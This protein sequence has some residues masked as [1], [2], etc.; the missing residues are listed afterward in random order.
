MPGKIINL[1]VFINNN[2]IEPQK[3]IAEISHPDE[4]KTISK[5]MMVNISPDE[6]KL[7]VFTL[8]IPAIYPA[9]KAELTI[10]I[11]EYQTGEILSTQTAEIEIGEFQNISMEMT[12]SPQQVMAGET[13]RS[14]FTIQN[15]G[16]TLKKVYIETR[17]CMVNESAEYQLNPGEIKRFT[18]TC[19]TSPDM[20]EVKK[21]F[22]TVRAVVSGEI[23]KSIFSS[24]DV[25]PSRNIKKDIYFRYPVTAS[26]SYLSTNVQDKYQAAYQFEISGNG[27]LDPEGKHRLEFMARGPNN[28]NLNFLGLYDQYFVSYSHKNLEMFVGEKAFTFTPLTESSRFGIGTENKLILNNGLS[29]GHLFVK[30]RFYN[31]IENE[32]AFFSN[33]DKNRNN[34]V[35]MYFIT[36]KGK[37][38]EDLTHLASIAGKFSLGGKTSA[39]LEFSRGVQQGIWDNAFNIN[40]NTQF[41]IF[42]LSGSYFYTGKDYPGYYSNSSFYSG[43]ATARITP[44]LNAGFYAKQDFA[45]AELDT[46]FITAPYSRILQSFVNYKIAPRSHLRFY[47]RE[48]ER[49]DRLLLKKFHYITQSL[50]SQYTQTFRKV[51]MNVLAELGETTNLML[52][53]GKNRLTTYRGSMNLMYRPSPLNSFRVFGSWSNINSFVSDEQRNLTAGIAVSSQL[54]KNFRA[55]FHLQNA[56]DIDDYYLNRNLMQLNLDYKINR[57]HSLTFRSFYTIFRQQTE[58]PEFTLS[59]TYTY[60]FGVPVKQVIKAGDV[61][62]R[63]S[64]DNNAPVE[65]MIVSLL[66]KTAITDK[67]GEFWFRSVMPGMQLLSIDRSKMGVEE[68]TNIPTPIKI[69]VIEDRET[70]ISFTITRGAKL[71]G[72]IVA[73]SDNTTKDISILNLQHIAVELKNEFEQFR[74]SIQKDGSFSFPIIRPG[75][76]IFKIY[77]NTLPAG[78]EA[79]NTEFTLDFS[80]GDRKELEIIIKPKKRTIIFKSQNMEVTRTETI[81]KQPVKTNAPPVTQPSR[82]PIQKIY[83]SIQI[84]AFKRKIKPNSPFF[85]GETIEFEKHI[86]NLHKYFIG[87][88]DRYEEAEKERKRLSKKFNGAFV[89]TFKNEK[90]QEE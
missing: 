30:P 87:N 20:A 1:P 68:I 27:P 6:Q 39:E 49:K 66:N 42:S 4:W 25:F 8:Q 86:N 10:F 12:E 58:N 73:Q 74:I 75:K 13:F 28:S 40:A 62:G 52:P 65:G 64:N 45:N 60:H 37:E 16:N 11:K 18:I 76:W 38:R 26:A 81:V 56:Y 7:S 63:I 48:N 31:E 88:F 85:K 61:K 22:F 15:Q 3:V 32:M 90:L 23:I 17:N 43:N 5:K 54:W 80:P 51:E 69:E 82:S 83:Y 41:L 79:E 14:T 47:W 2:T 36:K 33:F 9:G 67:N 50:N 55:S 53:E 34:S 70:A 84:G 21:E 44:N 35:G 29:F 71:N 72:R 57:N 78:F 59:A 77:P 89:V 19:K 24:F 46:F